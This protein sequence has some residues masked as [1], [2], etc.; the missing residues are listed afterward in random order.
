MHRAYAL[1]FALY[2]IISALAFVQYQCTDPSFYLLI[3]TA[4]YIQAWGEGEVI[5]VTGKVGGLRRVGKV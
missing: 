5:G 2:P 1:R 3:G 4:V